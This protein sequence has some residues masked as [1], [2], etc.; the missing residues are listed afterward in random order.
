MSL[1]DFE[2]E[3]KSDEMRPGRF[4]RIVGGET[5]VCTHRTAESRYEAQSSSSALE[6][7]AAMI[8][9]PRVGEG[10]GEGDLHLELA[11]ARISMLAERL[12]GELGGYRRYIAAKALAG[13]FAL[14]A[15]ASV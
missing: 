15:A 14:P 6:Q 3:C 13:A 5:I 8:A 4:V 1:A 2:T 10:E 9:A 12:P 11:W 7:H